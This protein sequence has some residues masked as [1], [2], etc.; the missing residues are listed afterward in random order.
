[1]MPSAVLI[2]DVPHRARSRQSKDC[3]L[4]EALLPR[5]SQWNGRQAAL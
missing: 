3:D 5:P 4:M 2:F 1:M